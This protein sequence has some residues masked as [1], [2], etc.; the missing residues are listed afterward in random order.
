MGGVLTQPIW[1]LI[2]A[3]SSP[4]HPLFCHL[5]DA[6]HVARALITGPVF[7]PV[8]ERFAEAAGCSP[9]VAEGW[10][11]YLVALH[12]LG[13]CSGLFQAKVSELAEPLRAAGLF[14]YPEP[15]FRHE[16][17][18]F[19]W[20]LDHLIDD[21]HWNEESARTV[22]SALR[23]H[24]GDLGAET[25]AE[26]PEEMA[27][28]WD[29]L[30]R[31]LVEAVRQV[32]QPPPWQP[33]FRHHSAAGL[34]LAGLTVLAD[35]LASNEE[36]FPLRWRGESWEDYIARSQEVAQAAVARVGLS[37]PLPWQPQPPF[38]AIWPRLASP[39]PAQRL[40]E[41]LVQEGMR[42]GL[43]IV[44][45]QMG[46]GKSEAALYLA[47]AWLGE[48]AAGGL[49]MA[50]PTAATS[51]QM[52][53]RIRDWLR[54]HHPEA[55]VGVQ[56]VHGTSW[57]VD[58]AI[59]SAVPEIHGADEAGLQSFDWFLPR[60]RSL[61]AP[62]GVGTIDQALRSVQ[63]VAHGFLRLFALAGKVLI[64]DEVHAYDPYMNRI[65]TLLLR[66]CGVLR[67][68]V[69][70]L[71]ATLPAA[72]RA[73]L[74][75]A[76][77]P[78]A[79]LPDRSGDAAPYP[80]LTLVDP[81]G[82]VRELG[83]DIIPFGDGAGD[84]ATLERKVRSITVRHHFGLLDDPEGVAQ[85]VATRAREGGCIAVIANT[86]DSAQRI[87][88]ALE[89]LL[90]RDG[91]EAV[92]LLLFHARFPAWRRQEIEEAVLERFDARSTLPEG[93]PRRTVRPARAVLIATQ[94]IEQSLDLD[95]DEMYTEAAPI[96]LLLQR[97]GRL[98]RHFRPER[99]GPATFHIFW[100]SPENLDFG[101][102]KNVYHPYIL[103][104]TLQALAGAGDS[105][106]IRLP[107]Q[108]RALIEAVYSEDPL[109]QADLPVAAEVLR[110]AREDWH[111]RIRKEADEAL[112]YL[113]PEPDPS[114]FCLA[115]KST[116]RL[117]DEADEGAD[118]YLAAKTRL[119]DYTVRVLLAEGDAF[120][121]ELAGRRPPRR[122]VLQAMHLQMVSI[123]AWW[124]SGVEP[125]P[126]FQPVVP[127]PGW[128]PG[129][130]VLRVQGG[131]W[132]GRSSEGRPVVIENHPVY[133]LVYHREEG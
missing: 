18:T 80:L 44:E 7:R 5:V 52:F 120:A 90:P 36:L 32:F 28:Q 86:V 105:M 19:T 119:G 71:S 104:R 38:A 91:P 37:G 125:E 17:L 87:Y 47:A 131:L 25:E 73:A 27:F 130:R 68:P 10:L 102:T 21:C 54:Q 85:C 39:R 126:G 9:A 84:S 72:R 74:A 23:G 121:A 92:E 33:V 115:A 109:P 114:L 124:L 123:P 79:Q 53:G 48:G 83:P 60:K 78:G 65:L 63:H 15:G 8:V 34:L 62:Y 95:F 132:R 46:G 93:D 20:L 55:A 43:A 113:V 12:D 89:R 56:L 64:V 51:N 35:W 122:E 81:E 6:G 75:A 29:A 67:V 66:W 133:G 45:D 110:R 100:P 59:P 129:V 128:L 82:T 107:D 118:R 97:A 106:E 24:H 94:V 1:R 108:I 26:E 61:L 3:K 103:L 16:V 116:E 127:A 69:I 112:R 31:E 14:L 13:K 88:Q 99:V 70:L 57:L 58:A 96:D 50:M 76:Y 117:W 42:P 111:E 77:A 30:R 40:A 49:Y 101:P 4:F 98:H 11:P 41:R 22:A 2:W